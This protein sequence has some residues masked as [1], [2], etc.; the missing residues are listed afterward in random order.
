[1]EKLSMCKKIFEKI[2]EKREKRKQHT[3]IYCPRCRNEMIWNGHF[4]NDNDEIIKYKCSKCGEISFWDFAHFP[5]P[6][7]RTCGDCQYIQYNNDGSGYC[8]ENCSPDI[9]NKFKYKI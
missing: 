3:F 4:I 2:K 5:V 1:M 9:Q 7:L 6:Y 8:N